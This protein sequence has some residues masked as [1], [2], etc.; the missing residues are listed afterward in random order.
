MSPAG[1][2]LR[3]ASPAAPT[4][5]SGRSCLDPAVS[6]AGIDDDVDDVDEQMDDDHEGGKEQ[7]GALDHGYVAVLDGVDDQASEARQR[8]GDLDID[9]AGDDAD[10]HQAGGGNHGNERVPQ[11]IG[12]ND[13]GRAQ[14]ARPAEG[15]I[16]LSQL[17]DH[18]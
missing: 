11:Q 10:D 18:G 4:G 3:P 13:A 14:P 6:Y 15:D 12:E 1:R 16:I 8:E 17:L 5:R 2:A 7:R 9:R